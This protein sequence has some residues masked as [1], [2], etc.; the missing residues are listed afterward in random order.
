MVKQYIEEIEGVP[1]CLQKLNSNDVH[2]DSNR[3]FY[4]YDF[5]Q[6]KSTIEVFY[7][8]INL[9]IMFEDE[10]CLNLQVI[11]IDLLRHLMSA[12]T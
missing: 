3:R 4:E 9:K 12:R 7:E 6:D 1:V 2:L 11:N 10:K 5:I 8:Q